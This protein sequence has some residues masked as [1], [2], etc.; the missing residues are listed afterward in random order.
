MLKNFKTGG[1][2]KGIWKDEEVKN[3][4]KTVEECKAS[5]KSLREAFLLHA[6]SY[7]RKANSVRNYYYHELDNLS[8]D[9]N[10]AENL[11]IKLDKH[12]KNQ[13]VGFS[14]EEKNKIISKIQEKLS[15][16]Y[17]VRKA[18]LMLSGGDVKQMLRMQNKYRA[19]KKENKSNILTFKQ[20][21]T[22]KITDA[23]INGLFMGLVKLVKKSALEE[24]KNAVADEKLQSSSAIRKLISQLGQKERELEFLKEDYSALKKENSLLKKKLLVATCF[25]AKSLAKEREKA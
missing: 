17:S 4:F 15:Q 21:V 18:C 23:D 16:G 2:M 12:Q 5:G 3:L 19:N 1:I 7:G 24:A 10:R 13:F 9:K 6:S 11:E 14:E 25:K 22:N 20:K 8:K